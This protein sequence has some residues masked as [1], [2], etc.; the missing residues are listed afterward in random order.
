MSLFESATRNQYRFKS[1]KGDLDVEML[2]SLPLQST[3]PNNADLDTIAKTINA[4]LKALSE[5]S[6][7]TP[8]T[9]SARKREL[10]E[11]LAIVVHI[12]GVKQAENEAARTAAARA[13]ERKRLV[14]ILEVRN[15]EELMKLSP[16]EIQA[17]I[18]AL[19]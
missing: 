11:K 19:G 3:K 8:N 12:I 15:S 5:D 17:K 10:E 14:E 1:V 13:A 6:F 7:V 18:D 16:A 4:E 2:W 9:N